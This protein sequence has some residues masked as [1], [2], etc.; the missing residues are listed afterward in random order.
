MT[1]PKEIR[2]HLWPTSEQIVKVANYVVSPI[3][4]DNLTVGHTYRVSIYV[5]VDN[6]TTAAW[7][8][9]L[10]QNGYCQAISA[11]QRVVYDFTAS[12]S[13][14]NICVMSK[15]CDRIRLVQGV[16][17][18]TADW[19]TLTGLNLPGNFFNYATQPE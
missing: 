14:Q 16:C 19:D 6:P 13:R 4:I 9:L 12:V 18:D 7:C 8:Q 2:N 15:R 10:S 1:A 3:T 5:Y 11:S 17:V